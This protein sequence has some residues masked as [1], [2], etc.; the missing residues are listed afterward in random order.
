MDQGETEQGSGIRDRGSGIGDRGSSAT[1]SEISNLRSDIRNPAIRNPQSA[2]PPGPALRLGFRMIKGM[3]E[4][5]V[6]G[7]VHGRAGGPYRSVADLS[8]RSGASRAV[9]ARLAAAGAFESL[10][11]NRRQAVWRVLALGGESLPLFDGLELEENDTSLPTLSIEE[12]VF[13]DYDHAGLSL[14]AHPV[15][16]LRPALEA[17]KVS[18]CAALKTTGHGRWI[19]VAG[20]VLVRQRPSTAKGITFM[21]LE[22][23][24]GVANL[25][26]RPNV[27]ERCR[28]A[29]RGATALIAGGRVERQGD[30]IHVSVTRLEDVSEAI[31]RLKATAPLDIV[32]QSH[33][34]PL[35]H[36]SRDFR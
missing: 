2:I 3:S 36:R 20:L 15:G 10:G 31:G 35:K 1:R 14:K 13:S 28:R 25:V 7:I 22:D 8:R 9:L 27:Y 19:R 26:V 4:A 24:S 32:G 33:K 18:A 17:L 29:A 11:L 30:V 6:A 34:Q 23:E 12:E 5:K 21:T 16:L